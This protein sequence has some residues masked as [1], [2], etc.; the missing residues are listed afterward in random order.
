MFL[1]TKGPFRQPHSLILGKVSKGEF[2]PYT[3]RGFNLPTRVENRKGIPRI[4]VYGGL[5]EFEAANPRP[6]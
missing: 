5:K 3:G 4:P 2:Y 6:Y 1:I